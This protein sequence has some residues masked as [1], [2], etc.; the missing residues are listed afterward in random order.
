MRLLSTTPCNIPGETSS[1]KSKYI[2]LVGFEGEVVV[3]MLAKKKTFNLELGK[4]PCFFSGI[5]SIF[6]F[7]EQVAGPQLE[8]DKQHNFLYKQKGNIHDKEL[9]WTFN[10]SP[11]H[12]SKP[13]NRSIQ[14]SKRSLVSGPLYIR[15][16]LQ[17][18]RSFNRGNNWPLMLSAKRNK[19]PSLQ[20]PR[21]GQNRKSI[22]LRYFSKKRMQQFG[23]KIASI[24][25]RC[26]QSS[27]EQKDRH[28]SRSNHHDQTTRIEISQRVERESS[29]GMD[30]FGERIQRSH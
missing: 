29:L 7:V 23:G 2:D 28:Q 5:G 13:L 19:T 17:E 10:S 1:G 14:R 30:R 9:L 11:K 18:L 15:L 16:G 3:K 25:A 6:I 20:K 26:S 24:H 27:G 22:P 8:W 12:S 21:K 4:I